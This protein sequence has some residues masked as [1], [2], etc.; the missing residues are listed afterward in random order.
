M[1]SWNKEQVQKGIQQVV[2]LF[3]HNLPNRLH[4]KGLWHVFARHGDVIDALRAMERL[5]GLVIYGNKILVALAK[6]SGR[7]QPKKRIV[8]GMSRE[9]VH[10]DLGQR[11][12]TI[13]ESIFRNAEKAPMEGEIGDPGK[14]RSKEIHR[15]LVVLGNPNGKEP[16]TNKPSWA[17]SVDER[18]IAN[19]TGAETNCVTDPSGFQIE[20]EGFVPE[21]SK[22]KPYRKVSKENL[23]SSELSGRSLS[24][25][26]L[27]ARQDVLT[28]EARKALELGKSLGMQIVGDEEEVFSQKGDY[29]GALLNGNWIGMSTMYSVGQYG[30]VN[31]WLIQ[32]QDVEVVL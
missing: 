6:Y 8:V 16:N 31:L 2:T 24:D 9:D 19:L 11:K 21:N 1:V 23:D 32:R 25:A 12:S 3:V 15:S 29:S 18:N 10:K 4:W 30:G 27:M 22:I 20:E 26:D 5:N 17:T 13:K 14:Q 7:M 28:R